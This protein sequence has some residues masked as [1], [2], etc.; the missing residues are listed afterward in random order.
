MSRRI[1]AAAVPSSSPL[2]SVNAWT[3]SSGGTAVVQAL[4]FEC[5]RLEDFEGIVNWEYCSHWKRDR[6]TTT[7]VASIARTA[8]WIML[9]IET[10]KL[11]TYEFRRR[12][13]NCSISKYDGVFFNFFNVHEN[14]NRWS[15]A[16]PVRWGVVSWVKII[17]KSQK[18]KQTN[19]TQECISSNYLWMLC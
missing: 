7:N 5:W 16:P 9:N 8:T 11:K 17:S 1:G 14:V 2:S 15:F 12:L 10:T 4:K 13:S 3:P 19:G 6:R 18:S